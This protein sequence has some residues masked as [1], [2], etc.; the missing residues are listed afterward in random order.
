MIISIN[1][2]SAGWGNY[3]LNGTKEKPRDKNLIEVIEGDIELGD[4]LSQNNKYEDSYYTI[5]LSSDGSSDK[6][7]MKLVYED[8]S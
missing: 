3:V 1:S 4:K 5:V 2:A 8:F 7:Q 6:E